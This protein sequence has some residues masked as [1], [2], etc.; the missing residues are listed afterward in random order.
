[1]QKRNLGLLITVLASLALTGCAK[2]TNTGS[3]TGSDTTPTNTEPTTNTDVTTDTNTNT[4]TNTEVHVSVEIF[5]PSTVLVGNTITLVAS[6]EGTS[7]DNVTWSID[8]PSIATINENGVVTGVSYGEV[9]VTAKSV[10]DPSVSATHTVTVNAPKAERIELVVHE[11]DAIAYNSEKL[12]YVAKVGHSFEIETNILPNNSRPMSVV[13]KATDATGSEVSSIS[14]ERVAG[15]SNKMIVRG[16]TVLNNITIQ[17]LGSY[18]NDTET[19]MDGVI[20]DFVDMNESNYAEVNGV[21]SSFFATEKSSLTHA[22]VSRTFVNKT[23]SGE[24]KSS[25][26]TVTEG[27]MYKD[28]SYATKVE[29]KNGASKTTK[30]YQG[31]YGSEFYCFSYGEDG[32]INQIFDPLQSQSFQQSGS[33]ETNITA[34]DVLSSFIDEN[35]NYVNYGVSR[36]LNSF[37]NDFSMSFDNSVVGFGNSFV[38][39]CAV[40][41]ISDTQIKITSSALD[42]DFNR[43]YEVELNINY[44]NTKITSYTFTEVATDAYG[45][46]SFKEEGTELNYGTL[47]ND[48]SANADKINLENYFLTD[49]SLK[50]HYVADPS[51]SYD[52][53]NSEKYG[54]DSVEDVGGVTKYTTTYDRAIVLK[55]GDYAPAN[56]NLRLDRVTCSSS[57]PEGVPA[58]SNYGDGLFVINA[59]RSANGMPFPGS[60]LLTFTSSRGV[61]KSI[62]VEFNAPQLRSVYLNFTYGNEPTYDSTKGVYSFPYI[63]LN[64]YT[65]YFYINTNPDEDKYSFG[66]DIVSGDRTGLELHKY[67]DGNPEGLPGFSY[68]LHGLK[69]G[70]YRFKVLVN[71]YGL[72]EKDSDG[73]D[74]IYEI[75]VKNL[76]TNA[77]L[78]AEL[79]DKKATYVYRGSTSTF[80][81]QFTSETTLK[82]VE[83]D[84]N[85]ERTANITYSFDNGGI[86][87][88][89]DQVI[90]ANTY[91]STIKKGYVSF[92]KDFSYMNFNLIAG[93]STATIYKFERSQNTGEVTDLNDFLNGKT[94]RTESQVAFQMGVATLSFNNGKGTLHIVQNDGDNDATMTFDYTVDSNKNITFSNGAS[95]ASNFVLNTSGCWYDSNSSQIIMKYQFLYNVEYG[96]G[97]DIILN[98]SL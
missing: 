88:A 13:Y 70:T 29:T 38:N 5:G 98:F 17:V 50:P 46:F 67:E 35:N 4:D 20:V 33:S 24:V 47:V 44:Q 91:F 8:N 77:E 96:Y 85:G 28:A 7:N 6:V 73:N 71:G 65:N 93:Q 78:K 21:V 64:E 63:Y 57:N 26:T 19:Y 49:Y 58:P 23:T 84:Y 82:Y 40:Y 97:M 16:F 76:L 53:S 37:L 83:K 34:E 94:F 89:N 36:L 41:A 62:L 43:N 14:F 51:G 25:L 15:T 81:F 54:I 60:A 79:V 18:P 75:E 59:G 32:A 72:Y 56:A 69:V 66:I 31:M 95:S 9:T 3:G 52:Y 22:K 45:S 68:S 61:Q 87:I 42:T 48:S 30:Y 92:A 27:K 90:G 80:T 74:K 2:S 39:A 55:I 11:S 86:Y 10:A 12:H 1:M